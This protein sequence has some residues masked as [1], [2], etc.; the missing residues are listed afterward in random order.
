LWLR[1]LHDGTRVPDAL[2]IVVEKD[3]LSGASL[4]AH[5]NT[6]AP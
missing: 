1:E 3:V 4:D 2:R 6:S 5:P